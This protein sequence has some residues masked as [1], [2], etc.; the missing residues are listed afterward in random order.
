ME[1]EQRVWEALATVLVPEEGK[2]LVEC[3]MVS[4]LRIKEGRVYFILELDSKRSARA[5]EIRNQAEQAVLRVA[6]VKKVS[7][8]LMESDRLRIWSRLR[9]GLARRD[10]TR[11]LRLRLRLRRS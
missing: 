1:L 3:R 9:R 10:L 5:Q 11:I 8:V 4:E 7:S 2:S 6:G